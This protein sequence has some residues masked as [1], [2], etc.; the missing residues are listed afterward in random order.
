VDRSDGWTSEPTYGA[1]V[2]RVLLLSLDA[3]WAEDIARFLADEGFAVRISSGT[4]TM[5]PTAL[6]DGPYDLVIADAWDVASLT[7]Q[8]ASIRSLTD[9]LLLVI[10]RTDADVVAATSG[11]ADAYALRTIAPRVLTARI[12]ALVRRSAGH[13]TRRGFRADV[14][15]LGTLTIISS[16]VGGVVED[17]ETLVLDPDSYAILRMLLLR[18]GAVVSRS[19]LMAELDLPSSNGSSLDLAV[20]RLREQLERRTSGRRIV[21]VRGVG[22]RYD[23]DA[24]DAADTA[25][26]QHPSGLVTGGVG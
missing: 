9:D 11:G 13:R 12:R 15:R 23:V 21:A 25:A 4:G 1:P 22:Y 18:P 24:A 14:Q 8:S 5:L 7:A 20:R 17:P 26:S 3:S 16:A 10:G 2:G 19:D 6:A